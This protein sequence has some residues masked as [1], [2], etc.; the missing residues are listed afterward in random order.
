MAV[1]WS[2]ERN[3][4]NE[5]YRMCVKCITDIDTENIR[6]WICQ[7]VLRAHG[8]V[9]RDT[10]HVKRFIKDF[11]Q[12]AFSLCRS[13]KTY[14]LHWS[15]QYIWSNVFMVFVFICFKSFN[16][17]VWALTRA[18][19]ECWMAR[20]CL[21]HCHGLLFFR[22]LRIRRIKDQLAVTCYFISFLICSTSF[23]H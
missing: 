4:L 22:H 15:V 19:H 10:G 11:W 2:N 3:V 16:V 21:P 1:S 7:L 23:G 12:V 5:K 18:V 14:N 6:L 13:T 8:I 9:V 17:T 20:W